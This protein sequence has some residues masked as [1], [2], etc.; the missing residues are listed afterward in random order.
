MNLRLLLKPSLN[1]LLVFVPAAAVL[2][3]THASPT[4]VF[5]CSCIAIIPLAGWMGR[6]TEHLAERVGAGL[7]GLLNATFGNAAE[8]IIAFLFLNEARQHPE[9]L[10]YNQMIV[11]ASLT[12]SIIGNILLVLG[13]ALLA[14]GLR[15]RVQSFNVTAARA[16]ATMLWL[17]AASLVVPAVFHLLMQG[18]PGDR[19]VSDISLE[20][21]ILLLFIYAL[22]LLFSL[23]THRHLFMG[24][25]DAEAAR[26]EDAAEHHAPWSV[27]RSLTILIVSAALVG[28]VSEFL[29][30]SVE[31]AAQALG[32]S[33]LFIGVIV[34][35]IIGNAAEH[36]TAILVAWRNRMDLSIGIAVGSSIQIALFVAP[37]LVLASYALGQPMSLVVEIS[38]VIAVL[39]SVL[40]VA[41]ISGDGESNG[42][43]GVQLLAVYAILGVRFYYL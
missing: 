37:V 6:A 21:A 22:N 16:G 43:E 15:H 25:A 39:L 29:V 4:A 27:R 32:M 14:G 38:E 8:L 30:G 1:W 11:K 28:V 40:V 19:H 9:K 41:P 23:K 35:A 18:Q 5:V 42:W 33:N 3:L 31:H 13:A 24:G 36:S 2:E 12:G 7:G 10:A 17:A 20:I 34:V 26:V